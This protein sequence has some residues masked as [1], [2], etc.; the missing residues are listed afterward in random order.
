ME[1]QPYT[2]LLVILLHDEVARRDQKKFGVRLAR[3]GFWLGKTLEIFDFHRLPK[4]NR[5]HVHDL[6]TGRYMNEKVCDLMVG[7]T[8]VGKSQ[9]K[10]LGQCVVRQRR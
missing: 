7:E 5:A 4:L 9:A 10:T 1:G 2:E 3:A 8:G 6:A